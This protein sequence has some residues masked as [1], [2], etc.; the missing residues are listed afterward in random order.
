[1][2]QNPAAKPQSAAESFI[3]SVFKYSVSTFVNMGIMGASIILTGL[4]IPRGVNG[5]IGIFLTWT[6]SI[7]TIAILGLDQALIRFYH[8]PPAGL[9]RNGLFRLCFYFSSAALL[10]GGALCS[11]LLARPIYEGLEFSMLGQGFVPLLFL[12]ALFYMVAR[13]FNVLYRMEGNIRVY[14]AESILMQFFYKLFYILG[15]FF[16]L[17][18]PVPAMA[19]CSAG[20]LGAFALV[21]AFLRRGALRPAAAELKSPAWRTLL[22]YGIAIAPT[23]VFITLNASFAGPLITAQ[24]GKD[25]YGVYNFA[26]T[27]SNI[28]TMVQ[29]GFASFWGPYMF[30]NYKTQQAR[31]K[32]V[33]NYV[34]LV[35][36]CFFA[37]LVA[38][39]DI[40]FI[41]F[42]EYAE[43][44][45]IFPLM[46][47]AA[48]FTILCETTV[49]GNTIARRPIYDTLGIGLSFGLNI[50]LLATLTA[51]LGLF[52]AAI[53]IA[54][55]N[56]AM[57]LFR[58]LSAQRFYSSIPN[59]GKTALA[60][61]LA[62]ALAV[63]GS[64]L[65]H[66]FAAK[67]AASLA[68]MGLYIL[69]YRHE[70][71][72]LVKLALSIAKGLLARRRS[73]V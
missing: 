40:L 57:F 7:M 43:A 18:N 22:P 9:S 32:R 27:L 11:T 28:V 60:A 46:M 41:I 62:V 59:P 69:M 3:G 4:F 61:A 67:L 66:N 49:Y 31:I 35:I 42:R 34:N 1:M 14:T 48:V 2:Q 58:T 6:N 55:A 63:A 47:L 30:E 17:A 36:L 23:A 72:R 19:L 71:I 13:Y 50:L 20:G 54:A 70:F 37:L 52:G 25:P 29:G 65:A 44:Q 8:K 15:A 38:A 39:E 24:L 45:P 26:Y 68:A 10:L 5:Q 53:A 33:H 16:G 12:N 21:F 64:L 51:P 73:A 56:G